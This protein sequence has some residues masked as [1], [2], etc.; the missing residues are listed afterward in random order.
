MPAGQD[1]TQHQLEAAPVAHDRALDLA[2]NRRAAH[3]RLGGS[4]G[5]DRA[6]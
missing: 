3:L 6:G 1:A 5:P 4:E 2:E